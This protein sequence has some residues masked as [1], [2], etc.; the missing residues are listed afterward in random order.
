MQLGNE[1]ER[2]KIKRLVISGASRKA[3]GFVC[4]S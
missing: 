1:R 4:Y 3:R 2:I